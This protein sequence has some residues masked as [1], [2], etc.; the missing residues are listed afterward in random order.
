MKVKCLIVDDEDLALDVIEEYINRIDYLQLEGKCKS[1]VEALSILNS[2]QIDLLFLDIQMPGL[3]GIQLLRNLSNPPTVIFTTAY[4][5]FALEGF[6]LEALDYLI[7]PIP[8]ERFINAVNRYFKLKKHQYHIAE[9]QESTLSEQPF[10]FVKSEKRMV[11]VFLH[12]ILYIESHRNYVSIYLENGNEVVTL[13]TISNIEEKL[14]E[15]NFLRIHRS[16]IVAINKLSSYSSANIEIGNK[17][18]PI[19]RN[20]KNMV[21]DVLDQNSIK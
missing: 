17:Q 10:I 4:S 20:Y 13:N 19:G 15:M 3:T 14:P 9:K 16:F 6:E 11:K 5:D 18:L 21:M 1:A 2:K 12:E 7:K 8:F